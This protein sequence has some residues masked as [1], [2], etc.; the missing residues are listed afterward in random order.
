M[1]FD[2]L[3][4]RAQNFLSAGGVNLEDWASAEGIP[5]SQ[6]NL[7]RRYVSESHR[8][9]DPNEQLDDLRVELWHQVGTGQSRV[10]NV[11]L[12]LIDRQIAKAADDEVEDV[13]DWRLANPAE[14]LA[15]LPD[16]WIDWAVVPDELKIMRGK[17]GVGAE[18][19]C[20]AVIKDLPESWIKDVA[21]EC[22]DD[23]RN[24][25]LNRKD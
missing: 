12:E 20:K 3:I 5:L 18:W 10:A 22:V 1:D 2:V 14:I 4:E 13:E 15:R 24:T 21:K 19:W 16:D 7:V 17:V 6:Y 9:Q 23:E 25:L 11:L 8:Y